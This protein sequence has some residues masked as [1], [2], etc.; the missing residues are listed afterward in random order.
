MKDLSLQ[1]DTFN[2]KDKTQLH[3]LS[4]KNIEYKNKLFRLL[5]SIIERILID[6]YQICDQYTNQMQQQLNEDQHSSTN[7]NNPTARLW[8]EIRKEGFQFLGPQMQ[9][10]LLRIILLALNACGSMSRKNLI[11]YVVYRLKYHYPK[12]SKTSVGHVVQLLYK[13]GCFKMQKRN[14]DSTLLELKKEYSK[15]PSLR[16]QHDSKIISIALNAGIRMS[17]EQWSH[18][19]FGDATH[20][21][22]MQSIIDT[23]QSELTLEKLTTDFYEKISNTFACDRMDSAVLNKINQIVIEVKADFEHFASINFEKKQPPKS[24]I[25]RKL[26]LNEQDDLVN[27][28]IGS[29]ESNLDS[30]E[31]CDLNFDDDDDEDE[32]TDSEFYDQNYDYD[33]DE[34]S[35]AGMRYR[36]SE[37]LFFLEFPSIDKALFNHF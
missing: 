29:E 12:A 5:R 11:L 14:G 18:K 19:L 20:K 28:L 16:R 37:T 4:K 15:Y 33:D 27:N 8:S 32:Y 3:E 17:P 23:L 9:D 1:K 2:G 22:E 30:E 36:R 7:P 26:R 21:S 10:D 34:N 24:S 13:T 6:A 25:K 31:S 35:D